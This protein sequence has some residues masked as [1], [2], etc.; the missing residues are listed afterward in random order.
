MDAGHLLTKNY[1][2]TSIWH[3]CHPS[4]ICLSSAFLGPDIVIIINGT[5]PSCFRNRISADS[6]MH[7]NTGQSLYLLS[8]YVLF[9]KVASEKLQAL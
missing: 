8:E 4:F 7:S 6:R 2:L 5:L 9:H 1:H 3:L